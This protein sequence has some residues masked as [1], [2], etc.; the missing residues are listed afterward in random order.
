M[1]LPLVVKVGL[2]A[3]KDAGEIDTEVYCVN[4][5][6]HRFVVSTRSNS[7]TTVDEDTGT[8]IEHGSKPTKIQLGPG[9]AALVADVAGWEWD[10]HV[11][12]DV[13]YEG[14]GNT[15]RG[16]YDLKTAAGSYTITSVNK[17]GD[18]VP[19]AY[20]REQPR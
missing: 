8:A 4:T 5:T 14:G 17:T 10:G 13:M 16:N 15:V 19:P 3:P 6:P 20:V 2:P 9:E 12:L 1:D 18:I 7:F 11:G